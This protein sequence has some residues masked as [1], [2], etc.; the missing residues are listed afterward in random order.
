M[1]KEGLLKTLKNV[2]DKNKKQLEKQLKPIENDIYNAKKKA[3]KK[4]RYLNKI[5]F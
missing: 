3:F 4:I 1:K 2:E 5:I